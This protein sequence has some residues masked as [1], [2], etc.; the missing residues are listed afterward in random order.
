MA[1][2]LNPTIAGIIGAVAGAFLT[3]VLSLYIWKKSKKITRLDC[4]IA[5]PKSL[6]AISDSI[7]DKLEVIYEDKI[8][9]RAYLF[10]I[11]I[12][13]TGT[14]PIENQPVRVRLAEGST[15]IDYRLESEPQFDFGEVRELK[16][17]GHELDVEVK[18]MNKQDRLSIEILSIENPTD[19]IE[20]GLKNKG[21]E[22]RIYTKKSFDSLI[23]NL[24]KDSK[25][26]TLLILSMMPF[27]GDFARSLMALQITKSMDK[28]AKR[29]DIK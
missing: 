19:E 8:V 13:N 3:G 6:L 25:L 29:D 22:A 23:S 28:I 10:L 20:I 11:E 15:I 5:D 17:K 9:S 24:T 1:W 18:L 12:V 2:Y 27:F 7:R 4:G 21:V 14:E 16:L 26:P